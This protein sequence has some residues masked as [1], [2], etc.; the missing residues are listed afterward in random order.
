M[1]KNCKGGLQTVIRFK[2]SKKEQALEFRV[3]MPNS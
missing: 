3:F 2:V 1:D